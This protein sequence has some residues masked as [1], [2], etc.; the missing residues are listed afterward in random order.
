MTSHTD[1]APPEGT[2]SARVP[3]VIFMPLLAPFG[4]SAGYV[5]VTLAFQLGRAGL[6]AGAVAALVAL[7]IWPQTW[8]I[9]WAPVVDTVG[10]PK[11]WY[12]LGAILVGATILL[13]SLHVHRAELH[14]LGILIVISSIASTLTSMSTEIFMAR[15]VQPNEKGRVSGWAQTGNLGGSGLGGGLG[16]AVAERV[17]E[18]WV[19][20]AVL[21]AIC[22]ACWA[23]VLILPPVPREDESLD[24]LA[25]LRGVGRA[26]W[27]MARSRPG[28]LGLILMLLPVGSGGLQGVLPAIAGEWRAGAD[29]VAVVN[30]VAGGLISALGCLAG[31]WICDRLGGVRTYAAFG[32][33]CGLVA[34]AMALA[35]RD[36]AMFAIF[37][38]LYAV[39]LGGCYAAFTTIVL[40][41]IGPGAAATK[42][43]LFA[44]ISNIPLA[45]MTELDGRVHDSHG[46]VAMLWLE[47]AAP[48]VALTLFFL[49]VRATRPR[50][51]A[52]APG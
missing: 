19:T 15:F 25:S 26:L 30:G 18:P 47:L 32:I 20:G 29:M 28:Y 11:L 12:G 48:A 14:L 49:L 36:P 10:N 13:M 43:N 5:S 2:S 50:A 22:I 27:D 38:L 45:W 1:L 37:A 51:A 40:E 3:P 34:V 16:L 35:P 17:A 9:L 44:A 24:Y 23:A 46:T 21:A 52:F 31:G 4:I 8:K 7:T 33:A 6:A 41:S 39:A 42:F